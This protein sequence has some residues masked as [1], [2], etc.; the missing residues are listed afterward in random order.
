MD[1]EKLRKF[2]QNEAAV[3]S[4]LDIKPR[5]KSQ[6]RHQNKNISSAVYSQQIS[7][8]NSEST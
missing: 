5:F 4:L 8:K 7:A 2:V 6:V 1:R 3:G